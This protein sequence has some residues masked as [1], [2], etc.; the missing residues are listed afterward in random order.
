[1]WDPCLGYHPLGGFPHR[2]HPLPL[3]LAFC[4]MSGGVGP[5]AYDGI[6]NWAC[7]SV[8]LTSEA[9][10]GDAPRGDNW[11]YKAPTSDASYEGFLSGRDLVGATSEI[12]QGKVISTTSTRGS[13]ICSSSMTA[14]VSSKSVRRRAMFS[15]VEPCSN[16]SSLAPMCPNWALNASWE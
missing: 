15:W 9:L 2:N 8:T 11:V 10:G 6:G 12:N 14:L 7:S 13:L 3:S 16:Y 5:L 4:L 1:L